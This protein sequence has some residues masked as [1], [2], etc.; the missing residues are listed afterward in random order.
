[1]FNPSFLI[2]IGFQMYFSVL[3]LQAGRHWPLW[4]HTKVREV[5]FVFFL[6]SPL[7]LLLFPLA[8]LAAELV[9]SRLQVKDINP[10][11]ALRIVGWSGGVT[12]GRR[13]REIWKGEVWCGSDLRLWMAIKPK[14]SAIEQERG[15]GQGLNKGQFKN[16][17]TYCSLETELTR[18]RMTILPV[19]H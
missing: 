10:G 18:K 5:I 14:P 8:S 13:K 17:S 15:G 3:V 2:F 4:T 19:N 16:S 1:M 6:S 12:G 11:V 9:A 7:S